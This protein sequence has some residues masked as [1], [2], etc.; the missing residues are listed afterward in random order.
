[1]LRA[2]NAQAVSTDVERLEVMSV[3]GANRN[4]CIEIRMNPVAITAESVATANVDLVL[5]AV[6]SLGLPEIGNAF[7]FGKFT[8]N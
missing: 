6:I 3:V 2:R 1:M 5:V 4:L 8:L 7:E